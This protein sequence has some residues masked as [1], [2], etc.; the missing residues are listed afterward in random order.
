[1]IIMAKGEE[2]SVRTPL[3]R[4]DAGYFT[5]VRG[6]SFSTPLV[7]GRALWLWEK[8]KNLKLEQLKAKLIT[9]LKDNKDI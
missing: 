3:P 8:D 6:T 2:I 4:L 7:A 5:T 1:M 9:Y